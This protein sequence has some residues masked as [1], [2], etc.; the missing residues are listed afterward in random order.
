MGLL[1]QTSR[2]LPKSD[3]VDNWQNAKKRS[4]CFLFI[5]DRSRFKFTGSVSFEYF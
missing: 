3:I 5:L 2:S 1:F 4:D